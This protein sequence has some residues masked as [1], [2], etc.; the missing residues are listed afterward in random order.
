MRQRRRTLPVSPP[1][2]G[3]S[4]RAFV[5]LLAAWALLFFPQLFQRQLFV[6]G[7]AAEYRPFAELSRERWLGK[8]ER[9]FWN[10]YVFMGIPGPSSLADSRPQYLPDFLLDAYERLRPARAVPLAGPLLAHLAGMLAVAALARR[11]WGA[12]DGAQLCAGLVWGVA[13]ALLVPF[14]FAHDAQLVSASLIPVLALC[15][16][17]IV[18]SSGFRAAAWA[19]ALALTTGIQIL[20]GHPQ[21]VVYGGLIAAAFGLEEA[22]RVR[23]PGRLPLIGGALLLGL[24]LS[25]AVWWPALLYSRE[26]LRGETGMSLVE[27]AKFS[28][29]FR[30]LLSL[31]W[32]TAV[33]F[34]GPTYWGA[35][36]RTD[37]SP[38]L[39]AT[40]ALLAVL[41]FRRKSA[42]P[43]VA[44]FCNALIVVAIVLSLGSHLGPVYEWLH[45]HVPLWSRFRV[46]LQAMVAAQ[47]GIALLAARLFSPE[48]EQKSRVRGRVP[49]IVVTALVA[50]VGIAVATGMLSSAYRGAATAAR[51]AMS[52]EVAER[53]AH[54]AGQDLILRL[55]LVLGAAAVV[56]RLGRGRWE[57]AAPW[58]AGILVAADLASV[59]APFLRRA[60]G[61]E[62]QIEAPPP[63]PLAQ[64]AVREPWTRAFSTK[65]T[66]TFPPSGAQYSET[67]TNFW[68]D[69]RARSL[70]G[71]HGAP[72]GLW[73]PV[74]GNR[75]THSHRAL[76]AF[77]VTYF[78]T[79]SGVRVDTTLY[80][81]VFR[82]GEPAVYRLGGA[83]GRAYVVPNVMSVEDDEAV[84]RAM[85]SGFPPDQLALTTEPSVAGR[86]SLPG[87]T[88][89]RWIADDP[90]RIELE[91][92]AR[93]P[94]FL[95][96][97]DAYFPG[98]SAQIDGAAT[99]LVRTNL[100]VRGV[101]VPAG[102]HRV[103]MTYEPEGWWAATTVT[104]VAFLVWLT[105]V[106]WVTLAALRARPGRVRGSPG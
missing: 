91:T 100:I 61:R 15:V 2:R 41:G 95:V 65:S 40:A 69:W 106:S 31:L 55:L 83:L 76:R 67:Y 62:S 90:D 78:A 103:R 42:N 1:A 84:I 4:R 96:V 7:D 54:E 101:R 64:R 50:L 3:S 89:V 53:A 105:L 102:R 74:I 32:P 26:S 20:N 22:L 99:P 12:G 63:P 81:P 75:L 97:A 87:E 72:P 24:A 66:I 27:V 77:G 14:T 16:H 52:A 85:K 93:A 33:G 51:P 94:A 47:L 92:E 57:R 9:T 44:A 59:S 86:Y 48:H 88:T 25:A 60:S 39:G 6:L 45:L 79:D 70:A 30:D 38:Y 36:E 73:R 71:T 23:R 11:L 43:G 104:R 10:P 46:P 13:P 19:L 35:M 58:A 21:I 68:I 17:A 49:A 56:S 34:G 5:L 18:E 28:L 98:W 82:P 80:Q 37:F 29:G 8:H